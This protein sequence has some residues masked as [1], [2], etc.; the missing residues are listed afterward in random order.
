MDSSEAELFSTKLQLTL[1]G[2]EPEYVR[3]PTVQLH[4]I[5]PEPSAVFVYNPAA[6]LGPDE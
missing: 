6:V 4:W 2:Q 5:F 1:I 3:V